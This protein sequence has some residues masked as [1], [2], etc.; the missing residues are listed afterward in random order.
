MNNGAMDKP[1]E[2]N[3]SALRIFAVTI[4]A[5]VLLEAAAALGV[6]ALLPTWQERGQF[7]DVFGVVN[8][9]F[10]ALAFS[11]L[12][13]TVILQRQD[14]LLQQEQIEGAKA[15]LKKSEEVQDRI[16]AAL[17]EHA[18]I[19]AQS[20][21][22]ESACAMLQHCRSEIE[23]LGRERVVPSDPR[24]RYMEELKNNETFLVQLLRSKLCT[25]SPNEA[26]ALKCTET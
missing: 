8:A 23:I 18:R 15:Q 22:L 11:A 6:C 4:G 9:T 13:Y 1:P 10:S 14:L 19:V 24:F 5:C 20:T 26:G 21:Q 25:K 17:A 2:R 16:A 12:V 3:R 7:G